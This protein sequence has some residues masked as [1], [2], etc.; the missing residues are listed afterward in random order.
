MIASL[1]H[2]LCFSISVYIILMF[3]DFV[4]CA[5]LQHRN[6]SLYTPQIQRKKMAELT[7]LSLKKIN[8]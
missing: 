1:G 3:S 2:Y 6:H 4:I 5:M 8:F 7:N